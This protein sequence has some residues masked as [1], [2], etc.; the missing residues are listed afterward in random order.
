MLS[1]EVSKKIFAAM[2]GVAFLVALSNVPIEVKKAEAQ[3]PFNF[4]G[5][6]VFSYFCTCSGNFLLYIT[7]PKDGF[8]SWNFG[9]QYANYMLP[10]EGVWTLGLYE[11]FGICLIYVG[12]SCEEFIRPDGTITPIVGTSF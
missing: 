3:N 8:F 10:S 7:P 1:K 4:G 5:L 9:P 11:P 12:E 6:V 2:I